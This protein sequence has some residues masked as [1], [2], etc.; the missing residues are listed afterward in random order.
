MTEVTHGIK[1][2]R[3]LFCKA[4]LCEHI[5]VHLNPIEAMNMYG[6]HSMLRMTMQA[7]AI[8]SA[9]TRAVQN[10]MLAPVESSEVS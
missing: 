7:S 5:I 10:M 1:G 6:M 3:V 4:S 8:E 2:R 9:C